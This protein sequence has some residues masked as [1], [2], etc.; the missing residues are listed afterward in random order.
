MSKTYFLV[1]KTKN[2]LNSNVSRVLIFKTAELAYEYALNTDTHFKKAKMNLLDDAIKSKIV[3][4]TSSSFPT[5]MC[6][7]IEIDSELLCEIYQVSSSEQ[8]TVHFL[9]KQLKL[10]NIA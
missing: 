9:Y 4:K 3:W 2:V 1:Y 10:L 7:L 6:K 8:N 5:Y